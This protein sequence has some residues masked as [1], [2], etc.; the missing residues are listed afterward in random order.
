MTFGLVHGKCVSWLRSVTCRNSLLSISFYVSMQEHRMRFNNSYMSPILAVFTQ[1]AHIP[2]NCRC[3]V[4]FRNLL[5]HVDQF[6][7]E[8]EC[9][10]F[11]N[12]LENENIFM[13]RKVW[14]DDWQIILKCNTY[15][16]NWKLHDKQFPTSFFVLMCARC[17]RLVEKILRFLR[18][19]CEAKVFT[20][21][22]IEALGNAIL[23]WLSMSFCK[24]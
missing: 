14:S 8:S 6:F 5:V 7:R 9:F 16:S 13:H 1:A 20:I 4:K 19:R 18:S 21:I 11:D 15:L 2:H 23:V 10:R 24:M 22:T 3:N 17:F 12:S